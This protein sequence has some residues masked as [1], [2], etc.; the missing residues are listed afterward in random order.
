MLELVLL[1]GTI[2]V[3]NLSGLSYEDR[4][5]YFKLFPLF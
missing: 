3:N 5:R 4:L 1:R 2:A